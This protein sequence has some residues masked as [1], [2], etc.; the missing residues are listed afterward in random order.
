MHSRP[1]MRLSSTPTTR[2]PHKRFQPSLEALEDRTVPSGLA[3]TPWPM[4]GMNAQHTGDSPYVGPQTGAVAFNVEGNIVGPAGLIGGNKLV[5]FDGSLQSTYSGGGFPAVA[6][7]GTIYTATDSVPGQLIAANPN[8]PGAYV[9]DDMQ[10][11]G[12]VKWTITI[13][14]TQYAPTIGPDGTIYVS[15]LDSFLYAV[16][17]DGTLKWTFKAG[18]EFETFPTLSPDGLTVYAGSDDNNLYAVNTATGTLR[19]KYKATDDVNAAH[20]VDAAG[21]V[22]F[23]TSNWYGW[24]VNQSGKLNWKVPLRT[25]HSAEFAFNFSDPAIDQANQT[26]FFGG[27]DGMYA[28]SFSGQLKWKY[29]TGSRVDAHPAIGADGMVYFTAANSTLYAVR[30]NGTLQ[31]SAANSGGVPFLGDD[32]TLYCGGKAFQDGGVYRPTVQWLQDSPDP[33]EP[34]GDLLLRAREVSDNGTIAAVNYYLDANA[35]NQ[36]DIGVDLL[37][38]TNTDG[39]N[40]WGI[41]I[42]AP[43]TPGTYTYFAQAIDNDGHASNVVTKTN[44]VASTLTPLTLEAAFAGLDL[45]SALDELEND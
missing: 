25:G 16:N 39:S 29:T 37:V 6:D 26:V 10:L 34:G 21:N 20:A 23:T 2:Q 35:N 14:R 11:I 24:S 45:M 38:G 30:P 27:F 41:T 13:G 19:W 18:Q 8:L 9:N 31:W 1:R 22:Y 32:G 44:T 42:T 15:G 7:D 33:V 40:F 4:Y 17:P 28:Y 43:A 3:N 36:L 12:G 5:N